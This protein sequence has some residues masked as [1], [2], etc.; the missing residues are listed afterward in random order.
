MSEIAVIYQSHYGSAEKYAKWIAEALSCDLLE[1]GSVSA[2]ALDRYNTVIYGGG[3][4]AGGVSGIDLITKN[5]GKLRDKKL[6]LFTC[7]IANPEDQ[8]NIDHIRESLT[9]VL[10][11]EMRE[12]I[13]VFHL[14]GGMD[15]SKLSFV[16]KAM[17]AMMHKLLLKKNPQEL[18]DDD[19]GVLETYGKSVDFADPQTLVPLIEYVKNQ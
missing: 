9:K 10:T 11:P 12:K 15:Y 14:R 4:Y 13:K 18:T 17:M 7:G 19:R 6:I 5:F 16:H 2:D 1:R 8:G 3:L